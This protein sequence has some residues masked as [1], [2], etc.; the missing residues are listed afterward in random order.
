MRVLRIALL[1]LVTV[2]PASMAKEFEGLQWK[3]APANMVHLVQSGYHIVGYSRPTGAFPE[4]Y[5]AT[6]ILQKEASVFRCEETAYSRSSEKG[7]QYHFHCYE[8]V[9]PF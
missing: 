4:P 1:T 6:Y 2:S 9:E 3:N 5:S 7:V 8:L